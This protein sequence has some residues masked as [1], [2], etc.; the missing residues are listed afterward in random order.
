MSQQLEQCSTCTADL[1]ESQIGLCDDCQRLQKPVTNVDV[2]VELM[3]YSKFGPLAQ[4]FIIDTVARKARAV[5]DADPATVAWDGGLVSFEAWQGV[6]R[7][8]ADKLDAHLAH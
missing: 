1:E 8:I 3:E 6:A 5:A 2:L 4:M 7:E